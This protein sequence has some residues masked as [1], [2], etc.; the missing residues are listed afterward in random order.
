MCTSGYE[1][2]MM[3]VYEGHCTQH[4]SLSHSLVLSNQQKFNTLCCQSA[5]S[6]YIITCDV[7][8]RNPI[9]LPFFP[10]Q[11]LSHK[12]FSKKHFSFPS[13]NIYFI[14]IIF[15]LL[16]LVFLFELFMFSL[17]FVFVFSPPLSSAFP[18]FPNSSSSVTKRRKAHLKRL[19]RRWTLGGIVN[20]QQSRGEH[21]HTNPQTDTRS[22]DRVCVDLEKRGERNDAYDS[23]TNWGGNVTK[24]FY[25][26]L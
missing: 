14:F 7:I 10:Y 9:N 6:F 15:I 13:C 22:D 25:T 26:L 18:L 8:T 2:R 20:R 23:F 16:M 4:W 1:E 24:Y 21:T 5:V 12:R 19:D 3:K 11:S 17:S